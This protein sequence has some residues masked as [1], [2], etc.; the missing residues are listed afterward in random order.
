M[1]GIALLPRIDAELGGGPRTWS[2]VVIIKNVGPLVTAD[3]LEGDIISNRGFNAYLFASGGGPSHFLK[4][5]P[6]RHEDFRRE[7]AITTRLSAH[8]GARGLVPKSTTFVAGPVRV[9][10]GEFVEGTALDVLIRT[11]PSR[12]WPDLAAEVLEA[13]SSM[14]DAISDATDHDTPRAADPK[15]LLADLELLETL[16][17]D[18]AA[19]CALARRITAVELSGR[20]QHGD[21][22][23]RNVLR[24]GDGW[25]VLD[26]ETCGE[27]DLPLYDVFHMVRGCA[28][29]APAGPPNWIERWAAAEA[30]GGPLVEAVHRSA[31]GMTL[32]AIEA[33]LTAY[34]V[35]FAA[36]LHRRGVS[37]ERTAGRIREL[38]ALPTALEHGTLRRLL[39]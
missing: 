7:A 14:W 11:P 39:G 15:S 9:L 35:E 16:G 25:R 23:P 21:F 6:A 31:R 20:P 37:R 38:N 32:P 1:P 3:P 30:A 12:P 2:E 24:V 34:M 19:S 10:A 18:S 17:L 28:E 5:R 4:I 29:A 27:V 13:A 33:A 22:W 8:P 36:R 26:F